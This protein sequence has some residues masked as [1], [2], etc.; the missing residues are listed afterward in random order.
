MNKLSVWHAGVLMFRFTAWRVVPHIVQIQLWPAFYRWHCLPSWESCFYFS[1]TSYSTVGYR[2]TSFS[3]KF[4]LLW[5]PVEN[6]LGTLMC[7]MS[8]GVLFAIMTTNGRRSQ[9]VIAGQN[10]TGI[11]ALVASTPR[12]SQSKRYWIMVRCF[13]LVVYLARGG[14]Y[15]SPNKRPINPAS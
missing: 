1:A 10:V 5:P 12:R 4:G 13:H 8:V 15:R 3:R 2:D 9:G 7:G 11:A 14:L 6:I